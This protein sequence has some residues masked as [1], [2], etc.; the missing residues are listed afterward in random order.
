[1]NVSEKSGYFSLG[2]DRRGQTLI[3]AMI[4][5]GIMSVISLG[6]AT[7]MSQ[8]NKELKALQENLAVLDL[9]KSLI[10]ATSSGLVC[11]YLLNNPA[12]TFNATSVFAGVPQEINLGATPLPASVVGGVPGPTLVQ[13]GAP[14]ANQNNRIGVSAV[15]FVVSSGSGANFSGHWQ[16]EFD[17]T[18]TV[19]ALRPLRVSS[20][21]V[22]DT[23]NPVAAQVSFCMDSRPPNCPSGQVLTGGVCVAIDSLVPP[24]PASQ[25]GM[26]PFSFAWMGSYNSN[27][28]NNGMASYMRIGSVVYAS[29]AGFAGQAVN[30]SLPWLR[31]TAGAV[32]PAAGSSGCGQTSCNAFFNVPVDR[33]PARLYI[34]WQ[35]EESN[36]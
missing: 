18:R 15:K 7:L 29:A 10:A 33:T 28:A 1:M 20:S 11:Q 6:F 3:Q 24:P 21:L 19:R 16:I 31:D 34:Y 36:N 30:Q 27:Q 4:A 17:N 2:R 35:G 32:Y 22:A 25:S 12:R 8:Q 13:A 9:E 26:I 5:L 23:T 14:I